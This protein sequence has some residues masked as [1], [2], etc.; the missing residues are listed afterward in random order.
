MVRS[1]RVASIVGLAMAATAVVVVASGVGVHAEDREPS[2][3][4]AVGKTVEK[5]EEPRG[6]APVSTRRGKPRVFAPR[7]APVSEPETAKPEA[8]VATPKPAP[9][10]VKPAEDT[11]NVAG[12]PLTDKPAESKETEKNPDNMVGRFMRVVRDK[13]G[14]PRSLDTA[15]VRYAPADGK[16]DLVVDLVGAVHIGE[17]AYYKA[18]NDLFENYDVVLF[19]L[20]MAEGTKLPNGKGKN[21][22][23]MSGMVKSMLNLESQVEKIDYTR[24]N[25]VHADLS[26][27]QMGEA[28]EKRGETGFTLTLSVV[29]D[30]MREANRR[31]AQARKN[32]GKGGP[33]ELDLFGALFSNDSLKLKRVM[34]DQM[35]ESGDAA[36]F[37]PTLSTLLIDDRNAAAVKVLDREIRKGHKKIAIYYGA[38]HLPDLEK[39]L[40]RDFA[41]KSVSTTWLEAWNLAR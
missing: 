28:M 34:A 35:E 29:T 22:G 25:F 24:K 3:R 9:M 6:E 7:P 40:L 39:R 33:S 31:E 17:K 27:Q 1:V 36:A 20:V 30:M 2:R 16:G 13:S 15:V 32:P 26:P 23:M 4:K 38:A 41:L 14:K 21:D 18:L 11:P 37:G 8:P 19:E 5:Q 12:K 10:P